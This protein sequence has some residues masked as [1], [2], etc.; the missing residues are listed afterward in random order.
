MFTNANTMKQNV[1]VDFVQSVWDGLFEARLEIIAFCTAMVLYTLLMTKRV[2]TQDSLRKK[3]KLLDD[4]DGVPAS[5]PAKINMKSATE[6]AAPKSPKVDIAKH[7][8][9]IRKCAAE[10]N[11]KGAMSIFETLK[12]SGI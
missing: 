10:N 7:V 5:P 4:S 2:V 12:E 9:M 8:M 3:T 1:D 6:K 11:L